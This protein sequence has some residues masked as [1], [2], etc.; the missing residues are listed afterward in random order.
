M[1]WHPKEKKEK[2]EERKNCVNQVRF[3]IANIP[4]PP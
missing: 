1:H 3:Q 4:A 2:N